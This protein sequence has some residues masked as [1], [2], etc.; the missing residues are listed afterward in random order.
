MERKE[1]LMFTTN[2]SRTAPRDHVSVCST[3]TQVSF[4]PNRVSVSRRSADESRADC[5]GCF[6]YVWATS[7]GGNVCVNYWD[8]GC[9]SLVLRSAGCAG[10]GVIVHRP[11]SGQCS[12][13]RWL[14]SVGQAHFKGDLEAETS[15]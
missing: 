8:Y 5:K 11:A 13:N 12:L 10:K 14:N 4:L 15:R 1:W 7:L 9:G 3:Q 2:K 6:D